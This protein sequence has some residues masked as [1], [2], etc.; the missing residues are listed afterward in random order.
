MSQGEAAAVPASCSNSCR[1]WTNE[2]VPALSL[3]V[4]VLAKIGEGAFG[5]VSLCQCPTFGRVAV[6]WIKPTKVSPCCVGGSNCRMVH[7]PAPAA[8]SP[9]RVPPS[10]RLDAHAHPAHAA[11]C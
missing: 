1:Q 10:L 6:K 3:Q 7:P 9:A 11:A 8:A 4:T 5:E 2:C